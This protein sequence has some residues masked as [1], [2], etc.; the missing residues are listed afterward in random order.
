MNFI[1]TTGMNYLYSSVL[2]PFELKTFES[3]APGTAGANDE[4]LH[5]Q[6]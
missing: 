5:H 2:S 1:S 4:P 3:Q 6:R